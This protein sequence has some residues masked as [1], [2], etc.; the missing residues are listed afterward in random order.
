MI[1]DESLSA[2]Q[3]SIARLG[4]VGIV[5]RDADRETEGDV[6]LA[7]YREAEKGYSEFVEDAGNQEHPK[8]FDALFEYGELLQ[9]KGEAITRLIEQSDT[10]GGAA[11]GVV[12]L[13]EEGP[14]AI[15]G[16]QRML[17][18]AADYLE[19]IPESQR[20]EAQRTDYMKARYFKAV[21]FYYVAQL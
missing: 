12:A 2:E 13:R 14:E 20:T 10:G 15:R 19:A 4:L 17:Q 3:R 1:G 7:K 9:S 8:F 6:K 11:E 5:K 16:A 18:R 21:N